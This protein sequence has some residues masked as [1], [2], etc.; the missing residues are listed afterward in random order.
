[1]TQDNVNLQNKY[2][3]NSIA[4]LQDSP[5]PRIH[6]VWGV[7]D[8]IHWKSLGTLKGKKEVEK[9]RKSYEKIH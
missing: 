2:I 1:M 7:T 3:A 9:E 6:H 5:L 4:C 8:G